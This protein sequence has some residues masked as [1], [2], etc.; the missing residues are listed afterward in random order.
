MDMIPATQ[1][2]LLA[3][4]A[5]LLVSCEIQIGTG[6]LSPKSR[7]CLRVLKPSHL[8]IRV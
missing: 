4:R 2:A 3:L 5:S 7:R 1:I 8:I 6:I